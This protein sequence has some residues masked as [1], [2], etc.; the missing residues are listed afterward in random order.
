MSRKAGSKEFQDELTK[1]QRHE[2]AR[3]RI[4][5][6][7]ER[8]A[9]RMSLVDKD[10]YDF[11]GYTDKQINMAFQGSNFGDKDYARLT[12]KTGGGEEE[13]PA[14]TPSP[15]PGGGGNNGGGSTGGNMSPVQSGTTYGDRSPVQNQNTKGGSSVAVGGDNNGMIDASVDNSRY[16]G[17]SSR[18]FNYT[19]GSGESSIYDSPVSKATMGGFYDVDDSP[20][21]NQKFMDQYIDSNFRRAKESEEYSNSTAPDPRKLAEGNRAFNPLAMQERIDQSPLISRD[22]ATI[23]FN[24]LFG[25]QARWRENPIPWVMPDAPSKIESEAGEIADDYADRIEDF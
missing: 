14:P 13:T 5:N 15:S 9:E 17:G 22:R 6:D 1:A 4:G 8:L 2:R 19:G 24:N 23:Q 20:A 3:E 18:T 7:P 12:G 11:S 25:D 16:Y 21:A 10:A